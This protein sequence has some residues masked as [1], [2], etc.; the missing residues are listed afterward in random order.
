MLSH[1]C[2]SFSSA[3]A[4]TALVGLAL[5]AQP[6]A[7]AEDMGAM[8]MDSAPGGEASGHAEQHHMPQ[9]AVTRTTAI[10]TIPDVTLEDQS[11]HPI[12]LRSLLDDGQPV[13]LNFIF[14]TCA[15]ICPVMSGTFEGVQSNLGKD[16]GKIRMVSISIDPENDTPPV[17]VRYA[18]RF[19]AG[20]QWLFLT[21]KLDDVI[22]VQ[23]AFNAFRGDKMSHTPLTLMRASP[24]ADWVRYDGFAGAGD[25]AKEARAMIGS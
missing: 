6:G 14:T 23:K 24:T 2:R 13:M 10:Y 12:S 20:D 19:H 25:L 8:M 16:A 21:G 7:Y 1:G 22:A 3:F 9:Q 5:V 17:L 11:G 4:L 15:G 18:K